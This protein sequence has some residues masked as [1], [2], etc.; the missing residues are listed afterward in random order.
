MNHTDLQAAQH[1]NFGH[2]LFACARLLDESAQ[3]EVN[4]QAGQVV[5]RPALMRVLPHLSTAGIRPTELARRLD[6]SKQAV[7]QVLAD[8][9]QQGLVE[10]TTDPTDGRAQLVRLTD[11]GLLAFAQGLGVLAALEYALEQEVGADALAQTKATLQLLLP[12]LERWT[13]ERCG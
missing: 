5:A 6:V 7:S 13:A 4:R 10:Q 2:L 3:A 11:A 9:Q 8:L 1:Q 12:V